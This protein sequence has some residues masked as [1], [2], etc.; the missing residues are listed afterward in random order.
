MKLFRV[1]AAAIS[2]AAFLGVAPPAHAAHH[3][4]SGT[5]GYQLLLK[6]P[7]VAGGSY[8]RAGWSD[9]STY[10]FV[11]SW[12]FP[13]K[14]L[15]PGTLTLVKP[16]DAVTTVF[17]THYW[18]GKAILGTTYIDEAVESDAKL[19]T[20]YEIALSNVRVVKN[21]TDGNG[22]VPVETAQLTYDSMKYCTVS[23]TGKVCSQW[24]LPQ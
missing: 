16:V 3:H 6:V 8:M 12:G 22:S 18:N 13:R 5:A 11:Q 17:Q 1:A 7:G 19:V 14:A 20:A 23:S 15:T 4:P 10:S 9:L 21:R 24:P 2:I